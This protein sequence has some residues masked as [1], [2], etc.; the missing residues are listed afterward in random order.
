MK[1]KIIAILLILFIFSTGCAASQQRAIINQIK[2][3]ILYSKLSND[4]KTNVIFLKDNRIR[5]EFQLVSEDLQ[6]QMVGDTDEARFA[7]GFYF[8]L[9]TNIMLLLVDKYAPA[10]PEIEILVLDKQGNTLTRTIATSEQL[11]Q[12]KKSGILSVETIE[13]LEASYKKLESI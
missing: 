5:I 8:A 1:I 6:K 9:P 4:F 10:Y 3:D 13:M 12:M 11:Q 7:V 2:S